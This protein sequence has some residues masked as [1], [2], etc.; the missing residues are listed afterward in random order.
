MYSAI[1]YYMRSGLLLVEYD[2]AMMTKKR[3]HLA[4]TASK[5]NITIR[6]TRALQVDKRASR[7][8]SFAAFQNQK[9]FHGI[10]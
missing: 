4:S 3:H 5:Q 1:G 2:D 7:Y 6:N 8:K 10:H 9:L